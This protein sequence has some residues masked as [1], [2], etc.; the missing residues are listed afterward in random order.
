MEL[1]QIDGQVLMVQLMTVYG[2]KLSEYG[3]AKHVRYN[4]VNDK[5]KCSAT[6]RFLAVIQG[7]T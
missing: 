2:A 7:S 3:A 5:A 1:A 6:S 4:P